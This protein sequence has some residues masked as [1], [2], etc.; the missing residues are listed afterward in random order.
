[1]DFREQKN[2]N[3]N[4]LLTVRWRIITREVQKQSSARWGPWCHQGA[5][6]LLPFSASSASPSSHIWFSL[7][8]QGDCWW[9]FGLRAS[10][11]HYQ[12]RK[13]VT[14]W[15]FLPFCLLQSTA[16]TAARGELIGLDRFPGVESALMS[17]PQ[18]PWHILQNLPNSKLTK[19]IEVKY[20]TVKA[21]GDLGVGK[22]FIGA[23]N[24]KQ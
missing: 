15:K 9:Q 6:F 14:P 22:A 20:K 8:L 16:I 21:L 10:L 23:K 5:R 4:W 11:L 24:L 18:C 13:R 7:K 19:H 12:E 2:L 17:Q 3:S 1:M